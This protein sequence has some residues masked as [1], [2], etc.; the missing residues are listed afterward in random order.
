[1]LRATRMKNLFI[2]LACASVVSANAKLIPINN[3]TEVLDTATDLVWLADW[4]ANGATYWQRQQSWAAGLTAGGVPAG[5]W[6]V[7]TANQYAQLWRNV[8]ESFAGLSAA[9]SHF[10]NVQSA[11]YWTSQSYDAYPNGAWY[12]N[13]ADGTWGATFINDPLYAAAVRS[14]S[15]VP[16]PS[17]GLMWTAALLVVIASCRRKYKHPNASTPIGRQMILPPSQESALSGRSAASR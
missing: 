9:T 8:G 6:S 17:T 16:E 12:V 5:S 1:M 13:P 14:A 4:N 15:V 11:A 10:V 2:F 7:P 3:G